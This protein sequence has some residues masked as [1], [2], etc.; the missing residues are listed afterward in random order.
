MSRSIDMRGIRYGKL[1]AI[2]PTGER[3]KAKNLIWRFLCDCGNSR[4][5]DGYEV[6]SGK[7]F[8]CKECGAET[9]RQAS[10]THGMTESAEY[11]IWTNMKTRC[12]NPNAKSFSR[13]GGRGIKMCS[14]WMHSFEEFL[15]DVGVRPSKDHS[16]DRI[17][18]NGDYE[19]GNCRWA[20]CIEQANNKTNNLIIDIDGTKKSATE[21]SMNSEVSSTAIRQRF[22][23]GLRGQELITPRQRQV[24][25]YKGVTDTIKG[26][27]DRIG[28]KY[29]TLNA[30]I[31]TYNWS[32]EQALTKG[33]K[34]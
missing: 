1:L 31:N 28:I 10:V 32:V 33:V 23:A 3:N 2:E 34:A 22:Y 14:K 7:T 29:S 30:R 8:S 11:K 5:A 15:N 24:I 12:C 27:S 19:P 21:W 18:V 20:T 9:L 16:I 17:D 25:S 26:W 4:E 13:Y 6:R